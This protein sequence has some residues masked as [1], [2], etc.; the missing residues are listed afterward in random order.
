MILKEIATKLPEW[1]FNQWFAI[2]IIP[3]TRIAGALLRTRTSKRA[4]LDG[5]GQR[6][7]PVNLSPGE[8]GKWNRLRLALPRLIGQ[9][10]HS[11]AGD[12]RIDQPET[13]K[14]A[15]IIKELLPAADD[16]RVDHQDQLV[17]QIMLHQ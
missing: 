11:A 14:L 10:G 15:P 8:A 16:D 5:P 2:F 4:P 12:L 13:L 3:Q 17:E 7:S 6:G 1:G 9:D